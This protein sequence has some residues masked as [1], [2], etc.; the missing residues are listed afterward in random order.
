MLTLTRGLLATA[1]LALLLAGC[2]YQPGIIE[3]VPDDDP[4]SL[5]EQAQQ[6]EPTQA[7]RTRLDAADILARQGERTQALEIARNIDDARLA[8]E[9]RARWALLLADLGESEGDPQ[10]V[11][12]ATQDLDGLELNRGQALALREQRG[13]ALLEVDEP[14]DAAVA[15][16]AVQAESDDEALNDPIWRA[17]GG[18]DGRRLTRLGEQG[19]ALTRGWVELSETV[20]SGGGDIE[21]LFLRL[22][23]WRSRNQRHPAA[24]R[25]PADLL[26]LREL[27]GQEVQ[28]I[29]VLLPESG[30]LARIAEAVAAGI[31]AHHRLSNGADVRLSFIDGTSGDLESLYREAENRGAQV[32]IGPLDK[33]RVSE[34]QR[35]DRVPL[36][37]LALNYGTASGNNPEGLFQYGLSAEDEAQQAAQRAWRDGHRRAALLVPDNDWGRRVGEAFWDEWRAQGG[38]VTRAVRYNPGASATESTRR[39]IAEA[40]PDALFMLALPDYARQVPPTLDYYGAPDLPV[41]ATSHLFSGRLNPRLDADLDDVLFLDIPWQIPDAAVGG[42]D[43]LP[44]TASYRALREES[45]PN[46]FRLN[47]MGVDALELALRLPQFQ[48]L[49]GS[50][51]FGATGTL[52]PGP[53]GRIQ[54]LLPWARFVNGVPQPVLIP[55]LFGDERSP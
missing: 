3:R 40:R 29:A 48:L 53:D 41:Y 43:A 26:A 23:D 10:A 55:G 5:L 15:L 49:S 16:L 20:R 36:P 2:A 45:D 21:R 7:A 11:I 14:F 18:L 1:L 22:D 46:L 51:L 27:S 52:R 33:D 34:L 25:L 4:T 6:Q 32:V 13:L 8:G 37:T 9:Q 50:E 31:R 19:G 17:L 35:R 24:R 42:E 38:E 54:R 12:R 30:P 28:H 47:A 44:F 39:T